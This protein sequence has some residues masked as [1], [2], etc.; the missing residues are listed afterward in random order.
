[1]ALIKTSFESVLQKILTLLPYISVLEMG[2]K[3]IS[4]LRH[5]NAPNHASCLFSQVGK[6][7]NYPFFIVD[8]AAFAAS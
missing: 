7:L 1:M 2:R 4:F 3:G 5:I 6:L 8:L